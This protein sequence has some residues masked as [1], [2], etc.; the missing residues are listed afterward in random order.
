MPK[1]RIQILDPDSKQKFIQIK[2]SQLYQKEL[3]IFQKFIPRL[4]L[5]FFREAD[6]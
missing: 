3:F 6:H 4:I 2:F 5:M 1:I